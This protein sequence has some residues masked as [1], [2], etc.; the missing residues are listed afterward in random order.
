MAPIG[1]ATNQPRSTISK[2]F[3]PILISFDDSLTILHRYMSIQIMKNNFWNYAFW[4]FE[5]WHILIFFW[6][7][8]SWGN[9][10]KCYG[11]KQLSGQIWQVCWFDDSFASIPVNKFLE[12]HFFFKCVWLTLFDCIIL[13]RK[14]VKMLWYETIGVATNQPRSTISKTFSPILI[15]F[16][17]SFASIH[18]NTD[19][20]E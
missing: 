3:S 5:V 9:L 8:E 11:M 13:I 17:D 1:V 12:E 14:L 6:E 2:T 20:E 16:D 18:V 7:T 10:W 15:S 19:H 4:N